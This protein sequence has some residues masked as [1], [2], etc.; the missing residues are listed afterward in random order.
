MTKSQV[1]ALL[2]IYLVPTIVWVAASVLDAPSRRDGG[3][4]DDA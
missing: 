4:E 3:W 1:L 2:L